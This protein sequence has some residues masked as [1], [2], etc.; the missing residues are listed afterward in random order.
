MA[1]KR[2]AVGLVCIAWLT[3]TAVHAEEPFILGIST[4]LMNFDTSP[5]PALQLAAAAGFDA[6]KDD[7]FW[8]T[9]EPQ[10]NQWR[11]VPPWRDYLNTASSLN[12]TRL[13]ILDYS[14]GEYDNAKPRTPA[15]KTG[16]LE[17][18]D[19][20]TRQLGNKVDFYEIWNEWDLEATKDP[21]LSADYATLVRETV[22]LIRK[23]TTNVN[24]TPA[25]ILAG[26]ITP[27]GMDNGFADRLIDA[28][29]LDLVDG[30]SIHPYAH[31]AANG[32]NNPESWVQWLR[33]Y[34]QHVRAKAGRVVP[35]YL[36]EMAWPSHKGPC[37]TTPQTQAAYMAR[38]LL[39]TRTVPNING[40]WW[41]DLI[42]DGPDKSDQ[43]HN[44]GVLNEDLS[45]KP[46]YAAVKAIADVIRHFTWDAKASI[47]SANVYQLYFNKGNEHVVAA[48]AV[49]ES[50]QE[51]I[52]SDRPMAG[53][54]MFVD[55]GA[56]EKG[57]MS[58]EVFWRCQDGQ[59]SVPVT[60]TRFPKLISLNSETVAPKRP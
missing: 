31:C 4:H 54:V 27:Q 17:Y 44:F 45:A 16:Y 30:L 20:V 19:Y 49:G 39:F 24:G 55:T 48:W 22:P 52:T 23:N 7:A 41:Y 26:S 2:L 14:T 8:S 43:E 35:I 59:C 46:A 57:Q 38:I 13:T 51:Q 11:I 32:R 37:G 29:M 53:P 40:I 60:L 3:C 50:R 15:V 12:L 21:Q 47:Q 25:R 6:V 36:T 5:E 28:G 34:E 56:P 1:G 58:G 42:N 33:D 10:P 18:V 9:A